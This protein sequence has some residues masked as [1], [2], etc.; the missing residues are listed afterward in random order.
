MRER[1]ILHLLAHGRTNAEIARD[2]YLSGKTVS[3]YVS[4]IF[5][6]LQVRAR[7]AGLAPSDQGRRTGAIWEAGRYRAPG[8]H[9]P[10]RR[11]RHP[12]PPPVTSPSPAGS[13]PQG[14]C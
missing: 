5:A 3:N 12:T 11:T 7:H 14:P 8:P 2:L 6:K 4:S 9:R 1:E 13:A 10:R